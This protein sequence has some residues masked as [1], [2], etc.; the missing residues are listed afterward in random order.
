MRQLGYEP[1]EKEG[2]LLVFRPPDENNPAFFPGLDASR[3][4]IPTEDL[5]EMIETAG[6][7]RFVFLTLLDSLG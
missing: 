5:T 6:I 4:P 1:I 3:D 2:N 7:N